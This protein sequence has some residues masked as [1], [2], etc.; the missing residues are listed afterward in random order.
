M[1]AENLIMENIVKKQLKWFVRM[2]RRNVERVPLK[3]RYT[4]DTRTTETKRA[5]SRK[6]T[7]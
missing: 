7:L 1:E 2:Q 3:I 4:N 5:V 6:A